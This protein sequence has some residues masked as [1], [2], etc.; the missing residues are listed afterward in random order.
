MA[1]REKV[2]NSVSEF[3]QDMSEY[4]LTC[5]ICF[6]EFKEPKSLPNCAHSV[7][8]QCLEKM[9]DGSSHGVFECPVCRI[10]SPIPSNGV[11]AWPTNSRIVRLMD[12]FPGRQDK[13]A[14]KTAAESCRRACEASSQRD[15]QY[16][17]LSDKVKKEVEEKAQ[18]LVEFIR[19]Q[20]RSLLN[21]IDEVLVSECSRNPE[22]R[23]QATELTTKAEDIVERGDVYEIVDAKETLVFQMDKITKELQPKRVDIFADLLRERIQG[24]NQL[25]LNTTTSAPSRD[26][27]NV[28]NY[29]DPKF[30]RLITKSKDPDRFY[31]FDLA[32]SSSGEIIV[33]DSRFQNVSIFDENGVLLNQFKVSFE[34]LWGMVVSTTDDIIIISNDVTDDG[35]SC[36][37]LLYY[38]AKGNLTQKKTIYDFKDAF[39][40]GISLDNDNNFIIT[41]GV[42]PCS[43]NQLTK[44]G[45]IVLTQDLKVKFSTFKSE[46]SE[47]MRKG[48]YYNEK[49][50]C[51]SLIDPGKKGCV[52]VFDNNGKCLQEFGQSEL[53]DPHGL[54]AD[55][56]TSRILVC[57][58]Q[59]HAILLYNMDG[60]YLT[61]FNTKD[62][63]IQI[64]IS[65]KDKDIF[66]A[67]YLGLCVQVI[68][69]KW[70]LEVTDKSIQ[71]LKWIA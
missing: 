16:K 45:V 33:L 25:I 68:S 42:F 61:R 14:I 53:C 59:L 7:C 8:L 1:T 48:I 51:T 52:K 39:L 11:K 3:L 2:G 18:K 67:C 41:S 62:D 29:F 6:E 71:A 28:Y 70:F 37:Y 50:Y 54:A 26:N 24:E 9:S 13:L 27:N 69:Y 22:L 20:E 34:D 10:E 23:A 21:V 46:K 55:P 40:T 30:S 56:D 44:G 32:M 4:E 49:Y 5:P 58:R 57:D 47:N 66:V 64:L 38:D 17:I 15:E 19:G 60:K 12:R 43:K 65:P 35:Q 31:P 63:P 36:G